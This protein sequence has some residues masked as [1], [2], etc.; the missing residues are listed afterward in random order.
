MNHVDKI[1]P[2]KTG[3]R[4]ARQKAAP[5]G[6][7][8]AQGLRLFRQLVGAIRAHYRR[9]E[10][11]TGAAAAQVRLL[12]AMAAP[13]DQGVDE[14]AAQ[15]SL[16][17]STVSNLAR[18]L[19]AKRL[20]TRGRGTQDRRSVRFRVTDAG[21]AL[22]RRAPRPASGLL[23][24]LLAALPAEELQKVEAALAM[25]VARLPRHLQ[26]YGGVSLAISAGERKKAARPPE[27]RVEA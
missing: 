18:Q 2:M 5:A 27:G 20:A 10:S 26:G 25:L 19:V 6:G 1:F 7:P 9:V 23:Q 16:H 13:S 24:E 12:A 22:L 15:L 3:S 8:E 14:L 4:G 17:K 11:K 21:R